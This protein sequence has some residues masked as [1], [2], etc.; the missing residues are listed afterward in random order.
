MIIRSTRF[1]HSVNSVCVQK[2]T[3]PRWM[4]VIVLAVH[5][6]LPIAAKTYVDAEDFISDLD[7]PSKNFCLISNFKTFFF[8]LFG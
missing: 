1:K 8:F 3:M 6:A 4:M 2:K 7:K 5:C